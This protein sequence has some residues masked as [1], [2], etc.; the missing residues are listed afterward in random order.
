MVPMRLSRDQIVSYRVRVNG[1]DRRAALDDAALSAATHVGVQDSM[2]RAAVLSL[3]ARLD[4]VSAEVLDDAR[5]E[6]VWGPRFSAFVVAAGDRA[7]FTLGRMPRRGAGR[8][9]AIRMAQELRTFL[10]GRTMTYA[11]AGNEM[12]VNPNALRYGTTTGTIVIRWEGS[13]RPT[14]TSVDAPAVDEED[15]RLELARRF[16]HVFG[17]ATVDDF[18]Q[19]AGVKPAE[20]RIT[21]DALATEVVTVE[22]PIGDALVLAIDEAAIAAPPAPIEGVRLLPSGD[23]LYLLWG[24]QR[25][26]FV[27]DEV[28]RNE[29]WTSRV[30]P[31]ALLLDGEFAGTWSR[32]GTNVAVDPWR[33]LTPAEQ[34]AVDDEIANLPLP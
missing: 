21:F 7:P 23:A 8:D 30:W 2:P 1:L 29:L 14:V 19:W 3:H 34:S 4:G 13:G 33:S 32:R 18:S 28:R 24:T 15:A 17:P 20:A 16:L 6:Q 11:E 31:G 26:L 25:G 5:L 12:G 9:R 10:D 27:G 22:T